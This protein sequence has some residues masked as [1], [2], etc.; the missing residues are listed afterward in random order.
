MDAI[1]DA[2]DEFPMV[3]AVHEGG[4]RDIPEALRVQRARP[5]DY[6]IKIPHHRGYEHFERVGEPLDGQ[7]DQ[8]VVFQWT[9]RTRI[10]E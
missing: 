4:P 10:A 6:K 8:R 2:S 1:N 7:A 5:D 3:E 9:N